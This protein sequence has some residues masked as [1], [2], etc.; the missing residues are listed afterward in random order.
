MA[1]RLCAA[2]A[3]LLGLTGCNSGE[4]VLNCFAPAAPAA[5]QQL[6]QASVATVSQTAH[7]VLR[8]M[9]IAVTVGE[10][11]ERTVLH[12]TTKKGGQFQLVLARVPDAEG[13]ERTHVDVVWESAPEEATAIRLLAGLRVLSS[14]K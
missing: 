6:V 2:A 10:E 8:E 7:G 1:R 5:E 11:G 13:N 4:F 14:R 3:L 9:G 12:C